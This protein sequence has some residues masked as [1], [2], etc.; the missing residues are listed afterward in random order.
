MSKDVPEKLQPYDIHGLDLTYG[1]GDEEAVAD[2]PW[3]GR[4]GKF[5]VNINNGMWRCLVCNEG[6]NKGKAI[7]GGNA[8][9]FLRKLW[10]MSFDATTTKD[11]KLLA[12]DRRLMHAS[13]LLEWHLCKSIISDNWLVPGY[14]A[15]GKLMTLY[16]YIKGKD[17]KSVLYPTSTLGHHIHGRNLYDKKKAVVFLC[18]GPWDAIALWETMGCGKEVNGKYSHTGN[19]EVS[20]LQDCNVLAVP[21][22]N[23]FFESWLPLFAGKVVNL[24]FDNDHERTNKKTGALIAPGALNGMKTV[25]RI[26]SEASEPPESIHYLKW[27]EQGWDPD[28]PSGYDVRDFLT[29]E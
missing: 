6:S 3:C 17:G 9:I 10:E 25:T 15:D 12:D 23:V 18:E 27:H 14:G 7:Q 13:S 20:L 16:Q 28:L 11:Y 8:Y 4:A 19:R 22:C 5:S 24:M 2:C 29:T 1:S 21:G 26:L